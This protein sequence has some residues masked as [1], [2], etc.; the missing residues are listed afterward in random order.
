MLRSPDLAK[1]NNHILESI[2]AKINL[3]TEIPQKYCLNRGSFIQKVIE[4]TL[5]LQVTQPAEN[6]IAFM[7]G[8]NAS[9]VANAF[10][11]LRKKS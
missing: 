3:V 8:V 10:L 9:M 2:G 6:F 1:Y 5:T 4:S 7:A 11:S